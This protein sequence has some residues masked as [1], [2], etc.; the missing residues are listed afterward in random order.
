MVSEFF[1]CNIKIENENFNSK[2]TKYLFIA[3]SG[4]I[5]EKYDFR[6]IHDFSYVMKFHN[7]LY[8]VLISDFIIIFLF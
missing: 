7:L 5:I 1:F 6:E 4:I 2:K 3:V 8:L